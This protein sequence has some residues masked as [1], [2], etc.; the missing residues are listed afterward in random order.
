MEKGVETSYARQ[1]KR[2]ISIEGVKTVTPLWMITVARNEENI[3]PLKKT[4]GTLNF[5]IK[6]QDYKSKERVMQC[7]RCQEFGHKAEFCN[8]KDKCVKCARDHSS[9]TCTKEATLPARCVNCKGDHS[10]NYSG[11]PEAK[12]YV[13]RRGLTRTPQQPQPERRPITVSKKKFPEL[14]RTRNPWVQ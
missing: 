1:I 3:N 4:T 13:E 8:I 7:F 6:V 12:K 14:P 5:L 10:A 2:N 9:R 11:C